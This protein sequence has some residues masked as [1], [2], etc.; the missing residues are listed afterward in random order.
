MED[1]DAKCYR[2]SAIEGARAKCARPKGEGEGEGEDEDDGEREMN[3][4]TNT[5]LLLPTVLARVQVESRVHGCALL[6]ETSQ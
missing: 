5:V 2:G 1:K 6:G 3:A 4:N